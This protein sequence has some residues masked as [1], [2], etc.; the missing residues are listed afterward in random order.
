MQESNIV[1][2]LAT[3]IYKKINELTK[4]IESYKKENSILKESI[5]DYKQYAIYLND[6][7]QNQKYFSSVQDKVIKTTNDIELNKTTVLNNQNNLTQLQELLILSRS[8]NAIIRFFK[9]I[10][11]PKVINNEIFKTNSSINSLLIETNKLSNT[12]TS[13]Q[14][15]MAQ[16]KIKEKE[17]YSKINILEM[18]YQDIKSI[19]IEALY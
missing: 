5:K 12:L 10:K 13:L 18:N 16:L 2:R 19:S 17:L 11:S 15:Q 4:Q 14:N 6:V 3:P 9:G 1:T 7:K 8:T